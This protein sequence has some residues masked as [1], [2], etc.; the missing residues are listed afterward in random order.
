MATKPKRYKPKSDPKNAFRD[1]KRLPFKGETKEISRGRTAFKPMS[2]GSTLEVSKPYSNFVLRKSQ[3]RAVTKAG[4][5]N[6][7]KAAERLKSPPTKRLSI[8]MGKAPTSASM[9][10]AD[11]VGIRALGKA[12]S[13]A[14]PV[15]AAAQT[16]YEIGDALKDT[17]PALKARRELSDVAAEFTGLAKRE[18]DAMDPIKDV[19]ASIR[20]R[21]RYAKGGSIDGCAAKGKTKGKYI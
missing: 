13:R 5:A 3:D 14:I 9:K 6:A 10:F 7:V 21:K 16:G 17:S 12:A 20:G 18:R 1:V 2:P 8:D 4:K 15:V 11:D 19:N